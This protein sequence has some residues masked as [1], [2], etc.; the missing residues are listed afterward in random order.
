[1]CTFRQALRIKSVP[2]LFKWCNINSISRSMTKNEEKEAKEFMEKH[3]DCS[4]T[5]A[6]GGKFSY[7]ITPTGLGECVS[8]RCNSCNITKDITDVESW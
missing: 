5:S 4:F 2:F 3:K 8:I 7:I 6:I 1:M